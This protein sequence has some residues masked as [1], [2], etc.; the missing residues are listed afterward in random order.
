MYPVVRLLLPHL[1]TSRV[2][3]GLR[4]A[5]VV[6]VI[7]EVYGLAVDSHDA[8][9]L[10]QW[11]QKESEANLEGGVK[12]K[13]LASMIPVAL[14][15][16]L[17]SVA[18]P[19]SLVDINLFLDQLSISNSVEERH[20]ILK[21]VFMRL[22][23]RELPW[24][25]RIVLGSST[26][27]VNEAT[28]L[29]GLD[30]SAQKYFQ[31]CA[32]LR[33]LCDALKGVCTSIDAARA[34][35]SRAG[36]STT[37]V[38]ELK[39][40]I[41]PGIPVQPML[42]SRIDLIDILQLVEKISYYVEE[43]IDGERTMVHFTLTSDNNESGFK[44]F[45]R[46]GHDI[47]AFYKRIGFL[48][49]LRTCL[50]IQDASVKEATLAFPDVQS[51]VLDGE[52]TAIHRGTLKRM[53]FGTLPR[54]LQ[55]G[56]EIT[57]NLDVVPSYIVF[58]IIELNGE[59][60]IGR[61][62]EERLQLLEGLII[63]T[64]GTFE[65]IK[66]ILLQ[67]HSHSSSSMTNTADLFL[68]ADF[69]N[70]A[71]TTLLD[72]IDKSLEEG[73]EGLVLKA[74]QSLYTP[75]TRS[76]FWIKIKADYLKDGRG[77]QVS[78]LDVPIM[79]VTYGEKDAF[80]CVVLGPRKFSVETDNG[81]ASTASIDSSHLTRSTHVSYTFC[82]VGNGLSENDRVI[83]LE[84]LKPHLKPYN[85]SLFNAM[86]GLYD[87][88][89]Q[90]GIFSKE[91][92]HQVVTDLFQCPVVV[93]IR[94]FE[95]I[96]TVN[97]GTLVTLRFPRMTA[98]RVPPND[99]PLK[100][101]LRLDELMALKDKK[102]HVTAG[103]KDSFYDG[104]NLTKL[105]GRKRKLAQS[106]STGI[107]KTRP[108]APAFNDS[109]ANESATNASNLLNKSETLSTS[110]GAAKIFSGIT[111]CLLTVDPIL[112]ANLLRLGA[113]LETCP[114]PGT[115]CLLNDSDATATSQLSFRVKNLLNKKKYNIIK[116][117]WAEKCIQLM[118]RI[119]LQDD[120]YILKVEATS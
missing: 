38:A 98:L 91:K 101:C 4:E 43:K 36:S 8:F 26:M 111:F 96:P 3:V 66:R 37:L 19:F 7:I 53:P 29:T 20:N 102:S 97:Y 100:D 92:P 78:D 110:V 76:P 113:T 50:R 9:L 85:S 72:M 112:S 15:D 75:G 14:R 94:G 105:V 104:K 44:F 46:N 115:L 60:V 40:Q 52:M 59:T 51:F 30:P 73:Q 70:G 86:T 119:P 16:R 68:P 11:R 58:D 118:E 10:T 34:D 42:A 23:G 13:D 95:L 69:P 28:W 56:G 90:F 27:A 24:F 83:L 116:I 65:S 88:R 103:W 71:S 21:K 64:P 106:R 6:K 35:S 74:S 1:D 25:I 77:G 99:K 57:S 45:S 39:P 114:S 22:S 89:I 63:E 81:L 33:R 2:L 108:L 117:G 67:P 12:V 120:D 47:T 54:L 80:W 93:T 84:A 62:L 5:Q 48:E 31:T 41:H 87:E 17:P 18:S 55:G 61:P 107:K 49:K 109:R 32:D 82:K 79:G